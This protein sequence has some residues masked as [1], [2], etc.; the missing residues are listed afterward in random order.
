MEGTDAAE[1]AAQNTALK[2]A[3]QTRGREHLAQV[4]AA[5]GAAGLEGSG[6]H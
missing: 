4:P 2:L 3:M 5:L 1:L 6:L